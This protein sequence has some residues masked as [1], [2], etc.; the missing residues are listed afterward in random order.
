MIALVRDERP[1]NIEEFWAARREHE[2]DGAI[3][4][5]ATRTANTAI[6]ESNARRSI[7]ETEALLVQNGQITIKTQVA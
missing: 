3:A 2:A 5:F 6:A 7:S 4:V 1:V